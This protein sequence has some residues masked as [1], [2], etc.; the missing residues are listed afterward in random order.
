MPCA[1]HRP[2]KV[3]R[4][5]SMTFLLVTLIACSKKPMVTGEIRD[6]FGNPLVGATVS[7]DKTTFVATSDQSGRYSV[8]YVPGKVLVKVTKDGYTSQEIALDIATEA[9]YPTQALTLYKIPSVAGIVAFAGGAYLALAKVNLQSKER[10][11]D[12]GFTETYTVA[13]EF[14]KLAGGSE[15][16]FLDSDGNAPRIYAVGPGGIIRVHEQGYVVPTTDKAKVFAG[17]SIPVAP[18]ISLRKVTL[19]KGRYA[20]SAGDINDHAFLFEVM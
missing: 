16:R 20:F 8:Q 3:S 5:A 4:I 14:V 13:G 6:G 1:H 17:T 11:W 9:E 12:A 10:M 7:V 19:P 18:G 2:C 15:L